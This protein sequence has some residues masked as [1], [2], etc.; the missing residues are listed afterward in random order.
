MY[1]RLFFYCFGLIVAFMT[2]QQIRTKNKE[3]KRCHTLC[4]VLDVQ[5]LS[6]SVEGMQSN[7]EAPPFSWSLPNFHL[8]VRKVAESDG[9]TARRRTEQN[10]SDLAFMFHRLHTGA[11]IFLSFLFFASRRTCRLPGLQRH[12]WMDAYA[13][14]LRGEIFGAYAAALKA[15]NSLIPT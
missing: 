1:I 12:H 10:H 8:Q 11:S 7:C 2:C 13:K 6:P 9:W 4:Y 5:W 14:H 3:I 15:L